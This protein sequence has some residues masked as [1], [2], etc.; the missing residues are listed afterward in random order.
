MLSAPA[1]V[2]SSS[3]RLDVWARGG[4]GALQHDVWRSTTNWSG[5]Q[6]TWLAGPTP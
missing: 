5:W 2:S 1:A 6:S 3:G 4:T